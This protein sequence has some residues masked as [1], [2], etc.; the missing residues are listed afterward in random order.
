MKTT[1]TELSSTAEGINSRPAAAEECI[2][3]LEKSAV[4]STQLNSKKRRRF[5]KMRRGKK[6][7]ERLRDLL[8]NKQANLSIIGV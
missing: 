1:V 4:E 7:E 2:R 8:N 3:D 5:L 6:H